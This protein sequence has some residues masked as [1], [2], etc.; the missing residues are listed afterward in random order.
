MFFMTAVAILAAYKTVPI[1]EDV[2]SSFNTP[3]P[4]LTLTLKTIVY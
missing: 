3:I 4:T 2:Y 1:I